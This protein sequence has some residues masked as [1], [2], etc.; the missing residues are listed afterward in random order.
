MPAVLVTSSKRR[1]FLRPVALFD[2]LGDVHADADQHQ[3][4]AVAIALHRPAHQ[5]VTPAAVGAPVA[6]FDHRRP[7][8][9]QRGFGVGNQRT[10][11]FGVDQRAQLADRHAG[12]R[13]RQAQHVPGMHVRI[14]AL[15]C[16]VDAPDGDVAQ[17]DGQGKFG[18]AVGRRC[19][20][21][22]VS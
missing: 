3:R 17:L 21:I 15:L 20:Q 5:Q 11:V 1:A 2:A 8:A 4:F 10:Q 14:H 13:R 7:P 12:F 19:R 16:D 22:G 18:R 9:G 6:G